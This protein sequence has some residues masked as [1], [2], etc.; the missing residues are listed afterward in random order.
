MDYTGN[1]AVAIVDPPTFA[2]PADGDKRKA[3]SVDPCLEQVADYLAALV[4]RAAIKD[5]QNVF[6]LLNTFNGRVAFNAELDFRQPVNLAGVNVTIGIDQSDL[7]IV[8]A[9]TLPGSPITITLGETGGHAP[10]MGARLRVAFQ[11]LNVGANVWRFNS[12]GAGQLLHI[13]NT[14]FSPG[15]Y[16]S[17]EFYFDGAHWKVGQV[18]GTVTSIP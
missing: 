6:A 18:S 15:L 14:G 16:T 13:D 17:L 5:L 9:G 8:P 7:F 3:A 11:E 4:H 2:L 1:P 10:A 12:E